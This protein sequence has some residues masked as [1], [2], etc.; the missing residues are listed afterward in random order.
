M[1][2]LPSE[3][4]HR[5]S[6]YRVLCVSVYVCVCPATAGAG[7]LN[8][9]FAPDFMRMMTCAHLKPNAHMHTVTPST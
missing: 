1:N 6:L 9:I 5:N 4:S 8:L 3:V 2:C 7:F